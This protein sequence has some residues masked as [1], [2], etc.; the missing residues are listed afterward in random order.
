MKMHLPILTLALLTLSSAAYAGSAS[1]SR[2][3][4]PL[5]VSSSSHPSG[6]HDRTL[7]LLNA[8]RIA[9]A[10]ASTGAVVAASHPSGDHDRNLL[11]RLSLRSLL[12]KTSATTSSSHHSG[13]H[14]GRNGARFAQ[15]KHRPGCALALQSKTGS[16]ACDCRAS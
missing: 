15:A 10:T 12:G 9:R 16:R 4:E 3:P 14:D 5:A 7:A 6:D 11:Q 2:S 13:D 1:A 8:N